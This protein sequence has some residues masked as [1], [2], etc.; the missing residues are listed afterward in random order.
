MP[1]LRERYIGYIQELQVENWIEVN[2]DMDLI[3]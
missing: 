3:I 2:R 1:V